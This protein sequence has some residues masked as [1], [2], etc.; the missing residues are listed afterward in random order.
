[1]AMSEEW[2]SFRSWIHSI[3]VVTFDL[4]LGQVIENT[5]PVSDALAK[6]DQL[7]EQDR[8]NI[9]Y[10]AFPDS[11]SGVMGD[12]QFHFRIRRNAG[13]TVGPPAAAA[14]HKKFNSKCL[15]PLQ[16]DHNFLFGF[17][18]FRQ[19]KDSSIRRGYYQKSV[20]VL[21]YL[22]LV[23]FFT[24][25]TAIVA[26]KFFENGDLPL[27]IFCHD[28]ERWPSPVPG[29]PKKDKILGQIL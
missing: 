24:Q 22:P 19:V 9:C 27:E 26:K 29:K 10:L 15:P 13:H 12:I 5:F 11:N 6:T 28:V 1:M 7:S 4:E 14:S 18:Y 17:A 8:T 21:T 2:G 25:I 16:F 23:S 3:V 20:I